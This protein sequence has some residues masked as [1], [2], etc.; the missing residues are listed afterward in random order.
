MTS[1]RP[2]HDRGG[3]ILTAPGYLGFGVDGSYHTLM[4]FG[5]HRESFDEDLVDT[6]RREA[7]E[8]SFGLLQYSRAA[9]LQ[10]PHLETEETLMFFAPSPE[11]PAIFTQLFIRQ[12]LLAPLMQTK[13]ESCG[14]FWIAHDQLESYLAI[15][16]LWYP[17]V[18]RAVQTYVN[19][20]RPRVNITQQRK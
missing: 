8:E 4:D 19:T 7:N 12:V 13:I 10:A 18:H 1:P 6:A 17:P 14:V 5:G 16:E 15:S 9:L 3:I 11:P 20:E 2:Y